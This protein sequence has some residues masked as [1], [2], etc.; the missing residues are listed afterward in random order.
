[1]A[2]KG[3]LFRLKCKTFDSRWHWLAPGIEF[4]PIPC[5]AV[6]GSAVRDQR[7]LGYFK[8]NKNFDLKFRKF[9]VANGRM[10]R[11][12][13]VAHARF[14]PLC[15]SFVFVLVSKIRFGDND[16]SSCKEHFG[17]TDRNDRTSQSLLHVKRLFWLNK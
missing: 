8:F 12:I 13:R 17:P 4:N 10:E 14:K 16:F 15:M 7:H 6:R 5:F 3:A 9:H 11:Y 1:M 2:V